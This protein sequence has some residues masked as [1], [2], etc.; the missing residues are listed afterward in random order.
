MQYALTERLTLRGGYLFNTNPIPAPVTLFNVQ[1]PAI[2]QNTLSM[3]ASYAM[4]ENIMASFA[5]VH[6]FDNSI[7]GSI[8]Q[9]PGTSVKLTSQV[10]Q[11]FMG[12]NM[13]F[14]GRRRSPFPNQSRRSP[15]PWSSR[16]FRCRCRCHRCRPLSRA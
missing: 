12:V 14:G 1:A 2:T 13:T 15:C 6:G 11:I 4:T 5:W 8:L 16:R 3:G 10:D 9:V 7:Q